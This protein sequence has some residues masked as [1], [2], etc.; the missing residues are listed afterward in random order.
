[1]ESAPQS[2]IT[3][4]AVIEFASD[5]DLPHARHRGRGG[6]IKRRPALPRRA[7]SNR[8]GPCQNHSPRR[9]AAEGPKRSISCRYLRRTAS[10][11]SRKPLEMAV[12]QARQRYLPA[13]RV[14]ETCGADVP[15]T[16]VP[17]EV[18]ATPGRLRCLR[19]G[20]EADSPGS[21]TGSRNRRRRRRAPRC[22]PR[23]APAALAAGADSGM[24][25]ASMTA[26]TPDA[27]QSLARSPASPS[28]TSIAAL[29]WSRT[30]L[31]SALRGCGTR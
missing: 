5:P 12:G 23:P 29:A 22:R 10:G 4:N 8:A 26:D 24:L 6:R 31:A 27:A 3:H 13:L 15:P 17:I 20:L 2:T 30:A 14:Q 25:G 7:A 28:D 19:E 18:T 16:I 1:M 11:F 21:R 9:N